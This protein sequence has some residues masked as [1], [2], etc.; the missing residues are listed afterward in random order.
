MYPTDSDVRDLELNTGMIV[1]DLVG[2]RCQQ[3]DGTDESQ[4]SSNDQY[5]KEAHGD[6]PQDIR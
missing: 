2:V 6:S 5:Q 1:V 3:S 4:A